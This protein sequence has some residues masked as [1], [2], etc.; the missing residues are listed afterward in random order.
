MIDLAR[1]FELMDAAD[2][3]LDRDTISQKKD[4]RYDAPDD[5]EWMVQAGTVRKIDAVFLEIDRLRRSTKA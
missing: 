3:A 4:G 2:E 1:L 5:A